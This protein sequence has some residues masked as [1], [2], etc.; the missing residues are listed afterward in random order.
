ML[1]VTN[2]HRAR[3]ALTALTGFVDETGVDTAT[4][5]I[6]DLLANLLHLGR[7]RGFDTQLLIE[8]AHAMMLEEVREDPEGKMAAVQTKF[9]LIVKADGY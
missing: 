2:A 9:R 6:S 5:A 1:E 8:R 4:S 7:G 3:W